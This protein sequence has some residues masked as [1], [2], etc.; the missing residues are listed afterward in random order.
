MSIAGL[1]R[2]FFGSLKGFEIWSCNSNIECSLDQ[3]VLKGEV[4][5]SAFKR[6]CGSAL[7]LGYAS[8]MY[9]CYEKRLIKDMNSDIL[10]ISRVSN[11]QSN[12]HVRYRAA[13]NVS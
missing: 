11:P 9:L 3:R 12:D 8:Y 2:L 4:L 7:G 13:F 1:L 10:C 6:F 5:S